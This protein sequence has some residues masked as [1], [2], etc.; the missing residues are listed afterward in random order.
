MCRWKYG[1]GFVIILVCICVLA[2]MLQGIA[3][4]PMEAYAAEKAV[5]EIPVG[6]IVL[7]GSY[8][9]DND[10]DGREP[11]EWIVLDN[12]D[13]DVLLLSRYVIDCQPY[14]AGRK[15][16]WQ[17]CDLR[18]W[19]NGDFYEAAFD[20]EQ[21]E[22]I[23]E[24]RIDNGDNEYY[25]TPGGEDTYDKVFLLSI[26][27]IAKYTGTK[28]EREARVTSYAKKCGLSIYGKNKTA[29]WWLRSPGDSK[30]SMSYV[31]PNGAVSVDG[32]RIDTGMG[33]RPALW[34]KSDQV[35]RQ[36]LKNLSVGSEVIFG[37]Y[38]QD[39]NLENGS[40]PLE[41][42][43]LDEEDGKALLLS[44]YVLD[45]KPYHNERKTL[46]WKA[47]DLCYWLNSEFCEKAFNAEQQ[48]QII[49]MQGT[50]GKI[51]LLSRD[52]IIKYTNTD[53]EQWAAI[54]TSY[55]KEQGLSTSA[56]GYTQ[57]WLRSH[58]LVSYGGSAGAGGLPVDCATVGVRPAIWITLD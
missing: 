1:K 8:E 21:Q 54:A 16:T 58:G 43:V 6:S 29:Y 25:D 28:P 45:C 7:F 52:E 31:D 51:F 56:A 33:V 40:E 41:W 11:L 12:K 23:R 20:E 35:F 34:V 4:K 15:T 10:Q 22:N 2:G 36:D 55:A 13:G 24:V 5:G 57:W 3:V 26:E 48:N 38:E 27:E 47:C 37:T 50:Y 18:Y 49:S 44:R 14:G 19:L 9:Q 17:N 30:S 42:I 53:S 39:N 46:S 32:D